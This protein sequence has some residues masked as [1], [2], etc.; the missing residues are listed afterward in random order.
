MSSNDDTFEMETAS[1][2]ALIQLQ[3]L[4]AACALVLSLDESQVLSDFVFFGIH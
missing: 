4:E 1:S 3:L 2:D